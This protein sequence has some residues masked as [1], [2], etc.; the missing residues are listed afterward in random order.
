M[1]EN[2]NT[3]MTIGLLNRHSRPIFC[4]VCKGLN[5][6]VFFIDTICVGVIHDF[7]VSIE[8]NFTLSEFYYDYDKF[9]SAMYF[10]LRL[11]SRFSYAVL[12]NSKFVVVALIKL[13]FVN[14][15]YESYGYIL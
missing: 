2:Q 1:T 11:S 7:E 6:I 3:M 4:R 5:S 10:Y 9:S 13:Y 14:Y 15:E 8:T 12:Y